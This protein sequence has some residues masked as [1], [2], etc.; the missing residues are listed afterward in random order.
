MDNHRVQL[1][2]VHLDIASGPSDLSP[3]APWHAVSA[4]FLRSLDISETSNKTVAALTTLLSDGG[5]AFQAES[6]RVDT[7]LIVRVSVSPSDAPGSAWRRQSA[8]VQKARYGA[9]KVLFEVLR[10]GWDGEGGWV[11]GRTV[12]AAVK[13]CQPGPR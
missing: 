13:H 10:T 11:M 1:G 8:K 7:G 9:L 12:C 4:D 6:R 2:T 3:A 5:I